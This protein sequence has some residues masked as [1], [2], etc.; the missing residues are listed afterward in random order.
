MF[1]KICSLLLVLGVLGG[2]M[3]FAAEPQRKAPQQ[4]GEV[5]LGIVATHAPDLLP[6]FEAAF[7]EHKAVHESLEV[8]LTQ[9]FTENLMAQQAFV[10]EI[11]GKLQSGEIDRKTAKQMLEAKRLEVKT[12]REA[13]KAELE[14]FKASFN[15]SP[16]VNK[17]L[18]NTLNEAVA[19]ANEPLIL[20]TLNQIYTNLLAHIQFDL[21]KLAMMQ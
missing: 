9:K 8:I 19:T 1:K 5:L 21:A 20:E 7:A 12:S 4:N 10:S 11:L 16:E 13:I 2:T 3:A 17:A 6:G 18:M 14:A 15:L